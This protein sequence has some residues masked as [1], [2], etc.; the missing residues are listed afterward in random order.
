MARQPSLDRTRRSVTFV[1]LEDNPD[2]G[3][4]LQRKLESNFPGCQIL[5]FDNVKQFVAHL[6]EMQAPPDVFILDMMVR[7]T[8]ADDTSPVGGGPEEDFFEA[9]ERVYQLL[10]KRGLASRAIIHSVVDLDSLREKSPELV[11]CFVQKDEDEIHLVDA[12]NNLLLRG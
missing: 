11:Q 3:E 4:S 2:H 7:Y 1:I 6:D 10:N 5:P 12:I 9:G 8:D